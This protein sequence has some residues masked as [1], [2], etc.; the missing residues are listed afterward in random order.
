[1]ARVPAGTRQCMNAGFEA[2]LT[3]G[4]TARE[5]EVKECSVKVCPTIDGRL[6]GSR[7][8]LEPRT[9]TRSSGSRC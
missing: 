9:M 6:A 4:V 5:V 8:V 1:M 7:S 3:R 2:K